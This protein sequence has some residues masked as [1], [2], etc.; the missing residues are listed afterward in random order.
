MAADKKKNA[1][2][3]QKK[4]LTRSVSLS[5][6]GTLMT[7]KKKILFIEECSTMIYKAFVMFGVKV[8]MFGDP[9]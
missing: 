2:E 7:W 9:N 4:E 6:A 1:V 3:K 8:Y 5:M